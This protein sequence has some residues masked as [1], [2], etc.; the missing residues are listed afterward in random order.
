M[1]KTY[2]SYYINYI[3][4]YHMFRNENARNLADLK[5]FSTV[6]FKSNLQ[7]INEIFI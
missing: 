4:I 6:F 3:I 7:C 1:Y 2:F 5:I